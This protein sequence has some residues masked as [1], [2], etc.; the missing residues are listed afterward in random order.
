MT[1]RLFSLLAAVSGAVAMQAQTLNVTQGDVTYS[2]RQD[3]TGT[4]TYQDAATLNIKG[5]SYTLSEVDRIT[6]DPTGSVADHTVS[7]VYSGNTAAVT[8]AGDLAAS[9]TVAVSGAD[10]TISN[11][12]TTQAV[13]YTLS[14]TATDGQLLLYGEKK[15]TLVLNGV[16]LTNQDGPAINNQSGKALHILCPAGTTSTLTD[17]TA[18]ADAY[19][20]TVAIDQKGT[21]FSEGQIYFEGDG[22]LNVNGNCKNAI[23]SDDYIVMTEGAGISVNA[24]T[25]S[26]G[27]NGVKVNDGMFIYGGTLNINVAADGA[28]GIKCDSIMT[29]TGGTLTVNTTGASFIE[30]DAAT[31]IRDTSS[32]A[33]IKVDYQLTLSGGTMTLTSTGEGGK[34]INADSDIVMTG[35]TLTATC[36]G[37]KDLSNPKAVKTDTYIYLSGGSFTAQST[38]GR[39]TDCAAS[40][41]YPTVIGTPAT[42][43]KTKKKV[44]VIF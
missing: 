44:V 15:A 10:V 42:N 40:D 25:A 41:R 18:Y 12:D 37:E 1:H 35:G 32:C 36:T 43:T 20:G 24:T 22:T 21:L 6:V 30:T 2:Y 39:A 31:G 8:V 14:G 27:S 34:G 9:M 4:M 29:M 38:N 33:G 3:S 5:K 7:I 28:K 26:T 16:S 17:G 13:T 23:A 11:T 19:R